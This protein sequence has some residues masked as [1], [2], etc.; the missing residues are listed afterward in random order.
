M[1]LTLISAYH[2]CSHA[3]WADGLVAALDEHDWRLVT[4]PPRHFAW[5]VRGSA[6]S[7]LCEKFDTAF[8]PSPDAVVATS[9]LDVAGAR[10]RFRVEALDLDAPVVL[11]P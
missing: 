6:M 10:R 1:R 5:R 9:M 3:L 8:S 7:L 11:S 4:L 2:A